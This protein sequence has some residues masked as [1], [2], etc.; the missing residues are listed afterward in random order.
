MDRRKIIRIGGVISLIIISICLSF[1]II[2]PMMI[3]P[4]NPA[5]LFVISN[6]SDFNHTV[7]VEI[8][9]SKN[10]SIYLESFEVKLDDFIKIDRGFDWCPKNR[11]YWLFWDEGT[12][13]FNVTLD[14]TYNISHYTE[15]YPSKSIWISITSDA[16]NPLEVH[17]AFRD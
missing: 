1:F 6:Y 3:L 17:D 7:E 11:F 14:E 15:L 4:P 5:S 10:N 8:F 2:L 12:Y 9:D 16:R 13:T